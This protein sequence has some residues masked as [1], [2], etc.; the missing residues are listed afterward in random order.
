MG[1]IFPP[2]PNAVFDVKKWFNSTFKKNPITGQTVGYNYIYED[3]YNL[4]LHANFVLDE[5]DVKVI[6][7]FDEFI[8]VIPISIYK[9]F[10]SRGEWDDPTFTDNER[11]LAWRIECLRKLTPDTK[12]QNQKNISEKHNIYVSDHD[13]GFFHYNEDDNSPPTNEN[14]SVAYILH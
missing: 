6:N 8:M 13:F 14:T 2:M 5:T 9:K 4:F 1:Y 7:K 3:H 11:K 12:I 10:V